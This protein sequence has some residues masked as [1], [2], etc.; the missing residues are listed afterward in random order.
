MPRRPGAELTELADV[1]E[2]EIVAREVQ[3]AVD[4]HRGMAAREDEAVSILPLGMGGIKSQHPV[5]QLVS[6]GRQRHR[7]AGMAG[8]GLLDRVHGQDA[9]AVD[10]P[11]SGVG[12]CGQLIGPGDGG[13]RGQSNLRWRRSEDSSGERFSHP[14]ELFSVA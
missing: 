7:G 11:P 4:Q 1:V 8:L 9:E 13:G 5:P 10:G 2:A 12:R 3:Q 6:R 14:S